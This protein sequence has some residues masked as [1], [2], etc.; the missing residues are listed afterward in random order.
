MPRAPRVDVGNEVYHVINRAN[1]RAQIFNNEKEYQ[2]FER[3]LKEAKVHVPMRILAYVLMPNHWHLVLHP[4]NDGDLALF[5]QWLT[6]THA[7]Q[8]RAKTKTIGHGH[9]YQGRY[10]SFLVEKDNYLIQ[11]LRYVERNPHRAKLVKRAEDWRWGSAWRRY[12]GTSKE[13]QLLHVP[14]IDL[15][16]GYR[17]WLNEK[18][19]VEQLVTIRNSVNRGRPL[20]TEGW[21]GKKITQFGLALTMRSRGRPKKGT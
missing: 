3:L 14:P 15:P 9:L 6:L 18:E 11:L 8:Y 12:H 10:K 7:Q 19:E 16:R 2:H 13:Q 5:M 1:N 21:T 4:E 20:G 17:A